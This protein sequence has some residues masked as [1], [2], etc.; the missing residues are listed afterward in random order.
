LLLKYSLV[1]EKGVNITEIKDKELFRLSNA[2]IVKTI[3]ILK[4]SHNKIPKRL[5]YSFSIKSPNEYSMDNEPKESYYQFV[6]QSMNQL[7]EIPEF[8][9]F[10]EH[11]CNDKKITNRYTAFELIKYSKP[12][13]RMMFGLL[14]APLLEKY[15]G[16]TKSVNYK[17]QIFYRCYLD[18]ENFLYGKTDFF[19]AISPLVNFT[20]ETAEIFLD[21]NLKIKMLSKEELNSFLNS[22]Y[23]IPF[24]PHNPLDGMNIMGFSYA[25]ETTFCYNKDEPFNLETGTKLFESVVTALR[26]F[27]NGSTD[28]TFVCYRSNSWQPALQ[29]QYAETNFPKFD[30]KLK[31]ELNTEE[32]KN[33]IAFW[34]RYK[35][36]FSTNKEK[37]VKIALERFNLAT[38]DDSLENKIIDY[39]ISLEALYS[40]ESNELTFKLSNRVAVLLGKNDLER[41]EIKRLVKCAYT[42]RSSIVHGGDITDSKQLRNFTSPQDFLAKVNQIVRKSI[43][44]F[45][46]LTKNNNKNQI[47]DAIDRSL[48]SSKELRELQ[49]RAKKF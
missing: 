26:L 19:T 32:S 46:N 13:H 20:S 2:L 27:K 14:L 41:S 4:Q 21:K 39:C 5:G 45:V 49:R 30:E 38:E 31:Y 42:L 16:E 3:D 1:N 22:K 10:S 24:S 8:Q 34:K 33:F 28:F 23:T 12:P 47:I 7:I 11:I 18:L 40:N 43:L 37:F 25:L 48:L 6:S 36:S 9:Q 29:E 15:F 44:N 35:K 17:Q